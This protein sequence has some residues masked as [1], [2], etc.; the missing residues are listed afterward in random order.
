MNWPDLFFRRRYLETVAEN[1][2][3]RDVITSLSAQLTA[4]NERLAASE[5]ETKDALRRVADVF[6]VRCGFGEV[7]TPAGTVPKTERP[8]AE[9]ERVSPLSARE[10]QRMQLNGFYDQLAAEYAAQ[11]V[12]DEGLED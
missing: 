3:L 2:K 10:R 7:F 11:G 5:A 4:A 1:T 8:E 12:S 6:A 9:P